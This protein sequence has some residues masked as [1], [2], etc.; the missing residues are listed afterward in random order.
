MNYTN[1]TTKLQLIDG[2]ARAL[3]QLPSS[4]V[5]SWVVQGSGS[6]VALRRADRR[7]AK[8]AGDDDGTSRAVTLRGGVW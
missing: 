8:V 3:Q 2:R 7:I 5:R 6:R 1:Y 4:S